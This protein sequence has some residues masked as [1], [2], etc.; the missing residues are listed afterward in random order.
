MFRWII[1]PLA[2]I[3]APWL[4]AADE[5]V[6]IRFGWIVAPS[7]LSPLMFSKPGLAPHAGKTYVP[8]LI[9]FSG[10]A[11][12]LT[13]LAA[14]ELD[15]TTLAYST[16][17]L[18][19]QNAGLSD[20]RVIMDSYEDGV[21]TFHTNHAMVR[22]DSGIASV[23]DLKGKVLATNEAGS[24]TDMA[25]RVFLAQHGLQDKR[26]LNMIEVP[27]PNMKAMLGD[28]KVA[29]ILPASPY[30]FDPELNTFAHALFTQKDAMGPTEMI[31]R[32]ARAPFIAAHRAALV[33]YAEDYVRLLQYLYDPAHHAEAVALVATV[34][35]QKPELFQDWVFTGNDYF[36]DP[37]ARP[38]LDMLQQNI[39]TQRK[40]GFVKSEIDITKYADLSLVED[41]AKRMKP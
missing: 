41:V 14:G 37:A 13:G 9:K 40:F 10:T 24:A 19:I 15:S 26:D 1:I 7:D 18:A 12:A 22:N 6:H 38:N 21:G 36:R 20:L 27:F 34:T 3:A 39:E 25:V 31:M 32:V 4:A 35:K 16:V 2:L 33:D 11:S 8:E 23:D 29:L 30:D 5:P 28:R 17:A